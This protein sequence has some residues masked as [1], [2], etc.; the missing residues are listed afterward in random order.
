MAPKLDLILK[1]AESIEQEK[2]K[3]I[4]KI[5]LRLYNYLVNYCKK[6]KPEDKIYIGEREETSGG[7]YAGDYITTSWHTS[8]YYLTGK[9]IL[10]EQH[11][12]HMDDNC[13]MS[14][15]DNPSQ[16]I[17]K[18]DKPLI[19]MMISGAQIKEVIDRL[20]EYEK[21]RKKTK[22]KT[23]NTEYWKNIEKIAKEVDSWPKWK[24]D[25][26]GLRSN[27]CSELQPLRGEY[28]H[29]IAI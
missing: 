13:K 8:K 14:E 19:Q 28:E 1:E 5:R 23:K 17:K 20:R 9:G 4:E 18:L 26:S 24:R 25:L 6:V 7:H 22:I 16:F 3:R 29:E 11:C 2:W 21:N 27:Y 10:L 15:W 12:K